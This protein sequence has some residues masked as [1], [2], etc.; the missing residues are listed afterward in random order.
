V[1][2]V[3]VVV[4]TA[5]CVMVVDCGPK[6]CTMVPCSG[7]VDVVVVEVWGPEVVVVEVVVDANGGACSRVP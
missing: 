7:V 4:V 1:E 5:G 6:C 2:G 3:R